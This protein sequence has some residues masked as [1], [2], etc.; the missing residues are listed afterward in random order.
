MESVGTQNRLPPT[1]KK[2]P[3]PMTPRPMLFNVDKTGRFPE[4]AAMRTWPPI[5]AVFAAT[6]LTVSAA[7]ARDIFVNNRSGDDRFTGH[8]R[9]TTPDGIGPVRTIEKA[10]RLAQQGDRIQVENTGEPYRESLSLMGS[11]HS[12]YLLEPFVL[13][14]NGAVLDGSAPIPANAWENYRG[15]KTTE[16][17]KTSEL[18][19]PVFRFQ[20]PRVQ[21]QQLFLSGRPASRVPVRT[22]DD[23]PPK[24]DSLQWCLHRGYIYFAVERQKLPGDYPL[25]YATKPAGIS[26]LAVQ[27]VVIQ[28]FV[29]QG[30]HLDAINA[31]ESCRMVRVLRV[32]CRGNGR[33]GVSVGGASLVEL[34][35]CL[36]G[37][38]GFAQLLTHPWSE[39]HLQNSELVSNT[40]PA[41]VDHGGKVFRDGKEIRGG[42]DDFRPAK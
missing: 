20:P 26:L 42:L 3:D 8:Q 24:L 39:T 35:Q 13:A 2:T 23:E 12:G 16:G 22:A 34:D 1:W 4:A 33:S 27:N 21:Y 5:L 9:T 10:L 30:F 41:W 37:D 32:T 29:I 19:K 15:D 28:D 14:G 17:T 7:S 11:R 36:V 18:W 31:L 38:N 25:S 40:A 6:C